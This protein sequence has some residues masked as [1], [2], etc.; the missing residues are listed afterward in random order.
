MGDKVT[1][2]PPSLESLMGKQGKEAL[3]VTIYRQCR[4]EKGN[5]VPLHYEKISYNRG[6][7]KPNEIPT[8]EAPN[9][10]EVRLGFL[11]YHNEEFVHPTTGEKRQSI[12]IRGE[13]SHFSTFESLIPLKWTDQN[14]PETWTEEE[15]KSKKGTWNGKFQ[16]SVTVS[17][18]PRP[19][20][21]EPQAQ[22][23]NETS[24]VL[25]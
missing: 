25:F 4:D 19:T 13:G 14:I 21:S 18:R 22:A 12:G 11:I 17:N 3:I 16:R 9:G 24:E 2:L 7:R 5:V 1:K 20:P 10:K 8:A 6:P 23:P 15:K